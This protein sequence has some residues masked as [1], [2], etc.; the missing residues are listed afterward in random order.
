MPIKGDKTEMVE[1]MFIN[2]YK[3]LL[4]KTP[5]SEMLKMRRIKRYIIHEIAYPMTTAT[6]DEMKWSGS[7]DELW[8]RKCRPRSVPAV[9]TRLHE[10]GVIERDVGE[11]SL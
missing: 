6:D 11:G 4:N 5:Q 10:T 8:I 9:L 7:W 1:L 3:S 2:R